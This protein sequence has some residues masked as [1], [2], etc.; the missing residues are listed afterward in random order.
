MQRGDDGDHPEVNRRCGAVAALAL[1]AV[2]IAGACTGKPDPPLPSASAAADEFIT[3]WEM[4][5]FDSV[6]A[7][8]SRESAGEWPA[9]RLERWWARQSDRGLIDDVTFEVTARPE[10]PRRKTDEDPSYEPVA[11]AYAVTYTS[12]AMDAPATLEGSFDLVLEGNL[13]DDG[14]RWAVVWEKSLAWPGI[15]GAARFEV[16]AEWPRRAPILDREGRKLAHGPADERVYPFGSLA[17]STIGHIA[18]ITADTLAEAPVG[19]VVG[20]LI[21]GSGLEAAFEKR[22][23]GTPDLTLG[24]ADRA[25]VIIEELGSRRGTKGKKVRVTLDV[26]VQRAAERGFGG[27]VGGA[28]I[29]QPTSGNIL[30]L[31]D[32]SSFN[33]NF[34]VGADA[35]SPFNR[36]LVGR[37]P[38]GS[39]MKV[40]TAAAALDSGK[41]TPQTRLTG[42]AEY[43]GVRNFESGSFG[44]IDFASALKFSVNTAFAQVAERLGGTR[45]TKYAEAFGFNRPTEMVLEHAESQYPEPQDLGDL[46]WSSI[47][48]AQVLATPLEMAT[49]AATIANDGRRMEPRIDLSEPKTGTRVVTVK[50]ADELTSMME[51]VVAGGTGVNARI[52]GVSIAGKTGT[53][54]VDIGGKRMNHAWFIAFAPSPAPQVAVA[55]VAELGGVGGQVAAPLA[56]GI[57]GYVLPVAP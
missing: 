19:R 29:V 7:S 16:A 45:L 42:P 41:F 30:A 52:S 8:L 35:L 55:V 11:V 48:Q 12:D 49:V 44:T 20:D 46:M 4:E 6:A 9:E 40:V 23:A 34:H 2:V 36:A 43:K 31:V 50:V 24:V 5:D 14:E 21:G 39:A 56:R 54:E 25:G 51:A 15:D 26:D 27:T 17:G 53:A 3:A 57:L 38:P 33:P 47:G 32:S 18:T 28:A 22:L 13:E 37:Y 10:R 1:S